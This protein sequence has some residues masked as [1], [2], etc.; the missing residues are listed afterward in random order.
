MEVNLF[1]KLSFFYV[2][3]PFSNRFRILVPTNVLNDLG[4][5]LLLRPGNKFLFFWKGKEGVRENQTV[6]QKIN[7]EVQHDGVRAPVNSLR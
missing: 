6:S 5:I 3:K 2:L 7:D 4:H 1:I